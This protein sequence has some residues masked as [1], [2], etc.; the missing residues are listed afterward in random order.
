MRPAGNLFPI[1]RCTYA[2]ITGRLAFLRRHLLSDD[3][4]QAFA[5]EARRIRSKRLCV[6]DQEL[7]TRRNLCEGIES[8]I[9]INVVDNE[10]PARPQS[11]PSLIQLEAHV[12]FRMPA[13]VDEQ[14]DLPEPAQ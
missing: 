14:I 12:A 6:A 1:S 10:D 4:E 3:A 2:L 8:R 7:M 9:E 11:S 5:V 13:I